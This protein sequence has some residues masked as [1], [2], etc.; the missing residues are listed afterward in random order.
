MISFAEA[1]WNKC[2]EISYL[3]HQ[4]KLS[5]AKEIISSSNTHFQRVWIEGQRLVAESLFDIL[6][7][8][9]ILEMAHS[10]IEY[11]QVLTTEL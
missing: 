8:K 11:R 1:Y 10:Q 9:F 7:R 2:R 3:F 5:K 6:L 4:T